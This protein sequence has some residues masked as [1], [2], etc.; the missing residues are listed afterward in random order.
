LKN[1]IKSTVEGIEWPALP[2]SVGAGRLAT[3]FQVEQSQWWSADEILQHQLKQ[4][5][6]LLQHSITHVP[7]YRDLFGNKYQTDKLTSELW[8]A[9]PIL[10]RDKLQQSGKKL[11][12]TYL[13]PSHGGVAESKTSGSTGKPVETLSSEICGLFWNVFSLR[14]HLWHRRDL[15][16]K[17]A[18]IRYTQNKAA[19]PPQG[20]RSTNWGRA[21]QGLYETGPTCWINIHTPIS[22]QIDWLQTEKPDYLLTHPSVLQEL[23][24]HCQRNHIQFSFLREVRTISEALPDGLRE[25]CKKVW[26]VPLI[27]VYTTIELGYLAL[28]C[29]EHNHYHV[30]SEGVF[31]EVLDDNGKACLSGEIGKVV[32]T[33]LHNFATPLIRYEVGDYALVGE[34]CSCGRGLPVIKKI[35]GR[36]RSLVTLPNGERRWPK[37]GM[38][39]ILKIAPVRQ[40]QAIQH[41]I[42]EVEYLLVMDEKLSKNCEQKLLKLFGENLHPDMRVSIRVVDEIA[43]SA[44]GKYEEFM[45]LL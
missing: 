14:D 41:A 42:T 6:V 43:R 1:N 22:E 21:T 12:T 33:S 13:P 40:Y 26:N 23:A 20:I 39:E 7:Y 44:S 10:T 25:L 45:S 9:I 3:L 19:K 35:L 38:G 18:V 24:L 16:G 28:Q 2:G 32:V 4:L 30:Q 29:P 37:F 34:P 36:Y 15:S 5:N 27:D 11:R 8:Q 17:L 31:L